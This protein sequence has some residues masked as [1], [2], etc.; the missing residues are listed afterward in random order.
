MYVSTRIKLPIRRLVCHECDTSV[1][2]TSGCITFIYM[3]GHVTSGCMQGYAVGGFFATHGSGRSSSSSIARSFLQMVPFGQSPFRCTA[4]SPPPS[5]T[6]SP[7]KKQIM[8]CLRGPVYLVRR[9]DPISQDFETRHTSSECIYLQLC[10]YGKR[11]SFQNFFSR[12][13]PTL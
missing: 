11:Q 6:A 2:V 13:E 1:Y 10:V 9:M 4:G 3:C 7:L 8:P 12:T 5:C